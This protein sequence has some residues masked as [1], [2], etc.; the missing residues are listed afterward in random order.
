MSRNNKF[1]KLAVLS[2][3]GVFAL[4]GCSSDDDEI[5]AKPSNY[6][7]EIV[8]IDGNDEKIHNDI[9]KIIYDAMHDGSVAS[10]TLD[11]VLYRYAQSVFGSYNK[12]TLSK[13]D[14][15][16]T[17]K[18]AAENAKA[19]TTDK[20]VVNG[21]IKAHKAYWTYNEDGKHINDDDPEN[22]VIVDDKSDWTPC[23]SEQ[24]RVADRWDDI[25]K[26]VAENMFSKISSGSYT[27][28]HFFDELKLVR[29]L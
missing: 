12:I 22:P 10:K 26:R 23:G 14:E 18:A 2:L 15:S 27:S 9:L 4:V 29:S 24:Q 19:D 7:D 17:L 8:T 3:L 21:F 28:K 20:S 1:R 11:A 6:K 5:Y 13:N 25:E 16:T